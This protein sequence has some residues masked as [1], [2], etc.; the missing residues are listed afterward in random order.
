MHRST[1]DKDMTCCNMEAGS[2]G[3]TE[4]KA[5]IKVLLDSL[6][7]VKK[8]GIDSVSMKV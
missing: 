7:C 3:V 1:A 2:V 8:F 4:A 5:L 6:T